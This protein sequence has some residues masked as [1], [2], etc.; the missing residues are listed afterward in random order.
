[1]NEDEKILVLSFIGYWIVLALLIFKSDKKLK[2]AFINLSIHTL[3]SS[4]F[5]YGLFYKSEGGTSLAWFLYLLF[6]IWSHTLT[7]LLQ[8]I[9]NIVKKKSISP[10]RYG[11]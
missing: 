9:Y 11:Q 8:T 3:Y 5:L 10:T 1:M 6:I 4:Y 7:N 2:T